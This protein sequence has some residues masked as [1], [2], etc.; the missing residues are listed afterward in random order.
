MTEKKRMESVDGWWNEMNLFQKQMVQGL[1][2]MLGGAPVEGEVLGVGEAVCKM[3]IKV[4][5]RP[6][7]KEPKAAATDTPF[8]NGSAYRSN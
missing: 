3:E 7:A 5:M 4:V 8:D 1:V 6:E 2:Q